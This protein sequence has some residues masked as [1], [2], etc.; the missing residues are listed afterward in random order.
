MRISSCSTD[1]FF[2]S[3]SHL[4][5][6][7]IAVV[8]GLQISNAD[9]FSTPSG[10]VGWWSGDGNATNVFGTNN[11]TLQGGAT[12]TAFGMVDRTF[13]FDGTNGY[14]QIPNSALFQPTNLT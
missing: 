12:A 4:L 14:V 1:S 13:T 3:I 2:S 11:G 7:L 9:C 10:L 6:A 5:A 8:F